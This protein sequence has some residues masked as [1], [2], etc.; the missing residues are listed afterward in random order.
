MSIVD[1]REEHSEVRTAPAPLLDECWISIRRAIEIT[2]AAAGPTTSTGYAT[3][4]LLQAMGSGMVG[5][6]GAGRK[7]R[8][9]SAFWQNA[10]LEDVF[11]DREKLVDIRVVHRF[12]EPRTDDNAGSSFR[13]AHI[14]GS[15]GTAI[16]H[17]D[18]TYWLNCHL[19]HDGSNEIQSGTLPDIGAALETTSN[20]AGV[21]FQK[22]KPGKATERKDR[23]FETA[24]KIM[25]EETERALRKYQVKGLDI[26][27]PAKIETGSRARISAQ[28]SQCPTRSR[29][30]SCGFS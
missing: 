21:I 5:F 16:S 6:A 15:I 22:R 4:T 26:Y 30:A 20:D 9:D 8:Q 13:K 1:L 12:T 11:D 29:F 19:R 27:A 14:V 3:G 28:T 17:D 23:N 7:R 18:L 25:K 10:V 24:I 2:K